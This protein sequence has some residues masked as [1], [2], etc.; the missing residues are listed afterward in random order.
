[1]TKVLKFFIQNFCAKVLNL[2]DLHTTMT[3][4]GAKPVGSLLEPPFLV[5]TPEDE[6]LRALAQ[7]STYFFDLVGRAGL[8]L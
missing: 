5:P 3:S 6:E 8:Y 7:E 2:M 4:E 1:M